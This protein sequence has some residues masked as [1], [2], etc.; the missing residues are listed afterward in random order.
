MRSFR[1]LVHINVGNFIKGII[2]FVVKDKRRVCFSLTEIK[3]SSGP[4]PKSPKPRILSGI[5]PSS[6]TSSTTVNTSKT[7]EKSL[8]GPRPPQTWI[9]RQFVSIQLIPSKPKWNNTQTIP[10]C[11]Q[12]HTLLEL[13]RH[14][15][16]R[17]RG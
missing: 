7:S 15:N 13:E 6:D 1:L 8:S 17:Q 12:V 16:N 4:F 9:V 14:R 5:E 3:N 10:Y 2:Q 11:F